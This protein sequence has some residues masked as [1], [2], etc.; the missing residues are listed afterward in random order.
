MLYLQKFIAAWLLPPGCI[1]AVLVLLRC[2]C[3]VKRSRLRYVLTAVTLA[4]YLLATLPV[5]GLLLQGLE[6]QYVPPVSAHSAGKVDAIV[7][8]GG[9]AVSN[10]PDISGREALSA[11]SMN[12]LITG[13]RLQKRLDVP[14]IISGGQVLPIAVRKLPWQRKCYWSLV[15]PQSRSSLILKRGI[16]LKMPLMLLL[17][18]VRRTGI[19]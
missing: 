16:Q 11:I 14:I 6:R 8:F 9:G 19:T 13:L 1:I 18:A 4:L 7:V 12:R 15:C 2:Y 5:A 3:F 17:Y 10:V